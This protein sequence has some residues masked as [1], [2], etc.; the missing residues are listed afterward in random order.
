MEVSGQLHVLAALTLG[1]R[2]GT[3]SL[4]SCVG[5]MVGLKAM[6]RQKYPCL[7]RIKKILLSS[8]VQPGRYTKNTRTSP[9]HVFTYYTSL[10]F[11]G[12][13]RAKHVECIG[14]ARNA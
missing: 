14:A 5:P 9:A 12:R 3:H 8:D 11:L 6:G 13:R 10:T 1:N 4:G 7:A 2:R